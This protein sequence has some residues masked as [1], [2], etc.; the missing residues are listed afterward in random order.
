[1]A[2]GAVYSTK[3]SGVASVGIWW[4][5]DGGDP[6]AIRAQPLPVTAV[7]TSGDKPKPHSPGPSWMARNQ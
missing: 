6:G 1:V 2:A 7:D 5:L 3:L 4:K